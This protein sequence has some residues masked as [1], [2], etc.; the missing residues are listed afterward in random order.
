MTVKLEFSDART[1]RYMVASI[2]KIIDEGV[3]VVNSE[4]LSLRALDTSHVVMI[5]LFY[6]AG[7]FTVFEVDGEETIGVS[8][9]V[10]SKVL[11]RARK[12]DRLL[13]EAE[14]TM[15]TV[16]FKS[17]GE[18]RFTLPQVTLTLEKLPEPRIAFSVKARMLGTTFREVVKDVEP[19]SEVLVLQADEDK[20]LFTGKSELASVEAELSMERG[21]LIDLEVESPAKS[22]YSLEYFSQ[23]LSAAQAAD[24]VVV[25]F[26][27]DVPVRVDLEY[28]QGGRLTFYVSP[29][30]E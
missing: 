11:R 12:D 6:P 20:L 25:Q 17:K 19:Y 15:M 8:F 9:D 5:D 4:G 2:E 21:S 16:A 30:V 26:S 3:F 23:M 18:R 24:A 10:F 1:W 22:S 27:D 14:G 29:R 13:I 28:L 7:A